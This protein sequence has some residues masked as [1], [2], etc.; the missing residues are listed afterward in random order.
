MG[1]Q[2]SKRGLLKRSTSAGVF[3]EWH[4]IFAKPFEH[5]AFDFVSWLG[6]QEVRLGSPFFQPWFNPIGSIA[7]SMGS[8]RL[9]QLTV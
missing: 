2:G 4:L 7:D 1:F 3:H 6:E 5:I 9:K 8:D